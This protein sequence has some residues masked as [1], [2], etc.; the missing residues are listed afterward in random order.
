MLAWGEI[1]R[2]AG[3]ALSLAQFLETALT[4]AIFDGIRLQQRIFL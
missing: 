4:I 3:E 2:K 1:H